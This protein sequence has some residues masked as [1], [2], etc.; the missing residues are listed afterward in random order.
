[1]SL[2]KAAAAKKESKAKA[3][4]I[5]VVPGTIQ[6][7]ETS[8]GE[9]SAEDA[10]RCKYI[11][12]DF[13]KLPQEEF[14]YANE[15]NPFEHNQL[16]Q[17][18]EE[19]TEMAAAQAVQ[20]ANPSSWLSGPPSP[21]QRASG[22]V[23]SQ[24]FPVKLYALLSQPLLSSIITWLPHGRSWRVINTRAFETSV[25]PVFFESDNYHS[26]NRV[27]NAWGFRRKSSGL[28]KGSYFHEVS[29]PFAFDSLYKDY[30]CGN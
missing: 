7:V 2:S 11:Y 9:A 28:D 8:S 30:C 26:F 17:A 16:I 18:F 22:L 20:Q 6:Q 27:I 5:F 15:S 4:Q 24:R 21:V 14:D 19:S 1:M 29:L 25:L 3:S 12:H 23:R 10:Q 13:A